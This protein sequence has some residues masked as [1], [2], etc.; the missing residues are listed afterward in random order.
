MGEKRPFP[1]A[2]KYASWD[3]PLLRWKEEEAQRIGKSESAQRT[4]EEY[5]GSEVL[6][7]EE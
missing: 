3:K 5:P 7:E 1:K 2:R 4:E 6:S